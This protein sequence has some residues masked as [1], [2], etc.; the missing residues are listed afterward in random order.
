MQLSSP[1][2][3]KLVVLPSLVLAVALVAPAAVA[4]GNAPPPRGAQVAVRVKTDV[5]VNVRLSLPSRKQIS[6]KVEGL[7]HKA[8]SVVLRPIPKRLVLGREAPR[9]GTSRS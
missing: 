1:I 9:T 7:A 6:Q 2:F 4:H 8:E 3:R 5:N